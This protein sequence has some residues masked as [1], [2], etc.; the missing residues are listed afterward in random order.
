[1]PGLDVPLIPRPDEHE[2]IARDGDEQLR[3]GHVEVEHVA[4]KHAVTEN[5]RAHVLALHFGLDERGS[6]VL[7]APVIPLPD[8]P[9]RGRR[10]CPRSYSWRAYSPIILSLCVAEPVS[11]D[12]GH[13][14][15]VA[16]NTFID[17]SLR[18]ASLNTG[19]TYN[20]ER[21]VVKEE[22]VSDDPECGKVV[23]VS[24]RPEQMAMLTREMNELL[25]H[26]GP[27]TPGGEFLR[28]YW[29]S[30]SL[31]QEVTPGGQ[32]KQVRIMGED[33]VLFRDQDGR[34]GLVG[35]HCSHRCVSLA[36]GRV[37]DGGIRCPMHG[38]VYDVDGRCLEQPAEPD[39]S[40]KDHIRHPAYPCEE[41]GGLIF[42]Y[43]VRL[44][45]SRCCRDMRCSCA[46]TE[47]GESHGTQS[48]AATYSM[49]KARS[50]PSA[51]HTCTTGPGRRTSTTWRRSRNRTSTSRRPRTDCGREATNR[52][53]T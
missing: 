10:H 53:L 21:G 50:T 19:R 43:W 46:R 44:K 18:R 47:R 38:W 24:R 30:M 25:T 36:Y 40:F 22:S 13:R 8:L 28:R 41:L 1:M 2:W 34:P 27:G 17:S 20:G 3:P 45:R 31:S 35:L 26:V 6:I 15:A 52:T 12:S 32:P 9:G 14:T 37:E 48:R 16:V 39:E 11:R 33:L 42:T 5:Q 4:A 29:H 51:V 23:P 7:E 49:W